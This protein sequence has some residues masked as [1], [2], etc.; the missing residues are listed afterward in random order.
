M[1]E[2]G[3]LDETKNCQG[4]PGVNYDALQSYR[5]IR[6]E[7]TV[8]DVKN[9][10]LRNAQLAIPESQQSS[11]PTKATKALIRSK[12]WFPSSESAVDTATDCCI[13]CQNNTNC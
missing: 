13:P 3:R 10:I 11:Y 12:V 4:Q 1:I 8:N 9:L 5:N 2:S 6:D 7:L